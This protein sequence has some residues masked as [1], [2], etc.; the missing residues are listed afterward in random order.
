M[1]FEIDNEYITDVTVVTEYDFVKDRN[2]V[3]PEEFFQI[4]KGR[5][6]SFS[7]S[8]KDHDEFTKLRNHLEELGYIKTERGWWNGDIVLKPFYLN[9]LL[10]KQDQKFLSAAALKYKF[11][12]KG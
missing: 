8:V 9:G 10:F 12:N 7:I 4:L 2:N 11:K 6:K 1:H 5:E 3:T